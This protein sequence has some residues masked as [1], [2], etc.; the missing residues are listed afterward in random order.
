MSAQEEEEYYRDILLKH[1]AM[2]T[3]FKR[4][5]SVSTP[6]RSSHVLK[7]QSPSFCPSP[8][9][10]PASPPL[11][12]HIRQ[13]VSG[14]EDN[15]PVPLTPPYYFPPTSPKCKERIYDH[16]MP[17]RLN[18][19]LLAPGH[20]VS[21]VI[22]RKRPSPNGLEGI[23]G[24]EDNPKIKRVELSQPE[25]RPEERATCIEGEGVGNTHS[26][27][28]RRGNTG[29][30]VGEESSLS[31]HERGHG[32]SKYESHNGD[33]N[34]KEK[35]RK[36]SPSHRHSSHRHR[37]DSK[38]SNEREGGRDK[39][40]NDHVEQN[41]SREN[42]RDRD[43]Y[44]YK[45]RDTD[46]IKYRERTTKRKEE[47]R[48]NHTDD[49]K[50][51]HR[52]R[53][54]R[55][56]AGR[57][58]GEVHKWHACHRHHSS[59]EREGQREGGEKDNDG[60]SYKDR[61]GIDSSG[62]EKSRYKR[63]LMGRTYRSSSNSP[64][65]SEATPPGEYDDGRVLGALS[66]GSAWLCKESWVGPHLTGEDVIEIESE[67]DTQ[68]PSTHPAPTTPSA[69]IDMFSEAFQPPPLGQCGEIP[70]AVCVPKFKN[71]NCDD[72]EGF[73]VFQ[74]G[75]LL[76]D[77]YVVY[78]V[79]GKGV[80]STALRAKDRKQNTNGVARQVVIKILRNN[81][82]MYKA[83]QREGEYLSLL[84]QMDTQQRGHCVRLLDTFTHM[85]HMCL[86]L[87][88]LNISLRQ[89]LRRYGGNGLSLQAVRVYSRQL[90]LALRLVQKCNLAHGDIKPDNI[91][92]GENMTTLYVCD[93]G[94]ATK[95]PQTTMTPYLVS[96][97]YRAPELI[98]GL[99]YDGAIDMWAVACTLY[100]LYTGTILFKG[101]TNNQ[102]LKLQMEL[103]GPLPYRMLRKGGLRHQHFTEDL[104]FI[105]VEPS[106][107]LGK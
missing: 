90:L 29:E 60:I 92:L 46:S 103:M 7:T 36:H 18:G 68:Q 73:H 32:L 63:G 12:P 52:R 34:H 69:H 67:E 94:T 72:P 11:S 81:D 3:R 21:L 37:N 56:S 91:M 59:R 57:D 75:E 14:D 33:N 105:S 25:T 71:D 22:N 55:E 85:G 43:R 30:G 31:K 95:T 4:T 24:Q 80:F 74:A 107:A 27:E 2:A 20:T 54:V 93:F 44:R 76:A 42:C 49:H 13:S 5:P 106:T 50:R 9:Y 88:S 89:L 70:P 45:E 17:K 100:E 62:E 84:A 66:P 99:P 102:M 83:G 82:M 23:F 58:E 86:V 104:E 38:I 97:F 79:A 78:D 35:E 65:G 53:R 19:G 28:M 41:E 61:D 77:R 16:V 39:Y 10:P 47:F 40:K 64:S 87:D 15:K 96:R 98:L 26:K 8:N 51:S 1:M 101:A 48:K 6:T